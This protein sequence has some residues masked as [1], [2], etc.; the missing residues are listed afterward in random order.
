MQTPPSDDLPLKQ[1]PSYWTR[2]ITES[3]NTHLALQRSSRK[4]VLENLCIIIGS[5]SL[6]HFTPSGMILEKIANII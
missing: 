4:R 3:E 2:F 1:R 5:V 6:S